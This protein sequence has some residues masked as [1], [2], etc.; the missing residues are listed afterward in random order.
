MLEKTLL[1]I[2]E[3]TFTRKVR[4]EK[5]KVNGNEVT[6]QNHSKLLIKI[7]LIQWKIFLRLNVKIYNCVTTEYKSQMHIFM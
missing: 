2:F 3:I 1:R 7:Y 4:A 5:S 6:T